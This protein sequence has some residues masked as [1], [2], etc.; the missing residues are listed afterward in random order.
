M[1]KDSGHIDEKLLLRFLLGKANKDEI[2]QVND[3]LQLSEKNQKLLDDYEAIWAEA[4]KLT[5][6]PVAVDTPLAWAKMSNRV[7]QYEIEKAANKSKT[8]SLNSRLAWISSSAAAIIII[9]FGI[10]QLLKKPDIAVQNILLAS[11]EN[12]LHDT[13]PDGSQIALNTNSKITYPETF[14]ENERR[15]KLEGEAFFNVEHNPEQPFIIEAGDAFI[16]VLGTSFNVKAYENSELEVIVT[17]GLVQLFIVDSETTDTSAILLKAGQKG[18]ISTK[19]KKPVYVA[20]QIPDALFWM[21]YTL[22][23]NDTD[24][25]KV[26]NL[27][28]NYYNIEIKVSDKQIYECRLSTTFSNNSIDDIIEVITATFEFEFTKEN[29]T[30]TIKGN[31]CTEKNI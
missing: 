27:L 25:Q 15:V 3:W 5:P 14:S 20:D 19:E 21:N 11:V 24:L 7:N 26:F 23:F 6:N 18:E 22:I 1:N 12:I 30:F 17:D 29:N 10:Y 9:I 4:G 31:G 2:Q 16:K 13:L 28:E 8:I